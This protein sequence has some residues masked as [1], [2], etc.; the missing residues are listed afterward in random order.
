MV[1]LLLFSEL[2]PNCS[3]LKSNRCPFIESVRNCHT[4]SRFS[5]HKAFFFVGHTYDSVSS[6]W[7]ANPWKRR[8]PKFNGVSMTVQVVKKRRGRSAVWCVGRFA[9]ERKRG[10]EESSTSST[11]QMPRTRLKVSINWI[12]RSTA[13]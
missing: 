2:N 5:H 6:Q 13:L 1:F 9:W 3:L 10:I 8:L 7:C 4:R 11:K 12:E